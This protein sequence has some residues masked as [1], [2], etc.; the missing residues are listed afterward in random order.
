M[1]DLRRLAPI[2]LALLNGCARVVA[3]GGGPEDKTPPVLLGSSPKSGEVN[4]SRTTAIELR[5]SE[6]IDPTTLKSALSI[7]P[8]P[9]RSPE[10]EVDGPVVRLRLREPLDSGSTVILRLGAGV[11]DFRRAA[12]VSTLEIPFSTGPALDSG[13]IRLRLWSG[14]DS[15]APVVVRGKV[16]LYSLDS[17][18]RKG[19]SRLLRRRDS[20]SWLSAAPMPWREKP[21]RWAMA[22]SQGVVNVGHLPVGRW[23]VFA[24]DDKDKDGYWRAGDEAFA[25]VGDLEWTGSASRAL[26]LGRLSALDTVVIPKDSS[27]IGKADTA[28]AKSASRRARDSVKASTPEAL[29]AKRVADS[30]G[31]RA[32]SLARRDSI[33][34]DSLALVESK[35]PEDS[36][37]V[38]RLDS[39][40]AAFRDSKLLAGR[41]YRADQRRR[42]VVLKRGGNGLEARVPRGGRW[43]GEIW[44]DRDGDGIIQSGDPFRNRPAEPWA[45]LKSVTDDIAKE[46]LFLGFVPDTLTLDGVAP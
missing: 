39:L 6:W 8:A 44:I 35:L 5:Y 36:S 11:S 34:L 19:L 15:A 33:R 46:D 32:D 41:L 13:A 45:P 28:V 25:W 23:R 12:I 38:V 9:S 40:P 14:F 42:P 22:D 18:R 37:R 17:S 27:A 20:V 7:M 2:L 10:I 24:W 26:F 1:T 30:L 43:G 3:P 29:A 21:W 31:R 4:V 16:G